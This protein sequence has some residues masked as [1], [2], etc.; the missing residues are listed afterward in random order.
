MNTSWV[1]F[2]GYEK[3]EKDEKA[4]QKQSS[5]KQAQKKNSDYHQYETDEETSVSIPPD[6][7]ASN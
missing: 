1:V 4:A 6:V 2:T 3:K 5:A 7:W